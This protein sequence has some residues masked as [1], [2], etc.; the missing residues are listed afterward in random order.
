MTGSDVALMDVESGVLYDMHSPSH[1]TLRHDDSN[2]VTLLSFRKSEG[3]VRFSFKRPLLMPYKGIDNAEDVSIGNHSITVV[4]AHSRVRMDGHVPAYHDGHRGSVVVDLYRHTPMS[5]TA[6]DFLGDES[7]IVMAPNF[8]VLN[9][10]SKEYYYA[11]R[12]YHF[13]VDMHMIGYEVS[14]DHADMIHHIQ[15]YV[16]RQMSRDNLILSWN[17]G[18]KPVRFEEM[19]IF[20]PAG[21]V[22]LKF[23]FHY[24]PPSSRHIPDNSSIRLVFS[25]TLRRH[26]V[27]YFFLGAN[28]T[29]K[30][31]PVLPI[32]TDYAV[33][34][35][36]VPA[37]CL[38]R[39][40]PD[41]V[42]EMFIH[43]HLFHM[44][45]SAIA[46]A[47]SHER[48]GQELPLL[49]YNPRFDWTSYELTP[50]TSRLSI[51]RGDVVTLYCVYNPSEV[52]Q[53]YPFVSRH[54]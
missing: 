13:P 7:E 22:T 50:P 32:D 36:T 16:T 39:Q 52:T 4:Y 14:V 33:L 5:R 12:R 44:H 54:D 38:F 3:D 35:V 46:S 24:I 42:S 37:E 10:S 21:D 28:P 25:P 19:G 43:R 30:N 45:G 20:F 34:S 51:K 29:R 31:A 49:G 53:L 1:G 41:E 47:V 18:V 9:S 48:D 40:Q 23:E 27:S 2:D 6:T 17:R 26:N 15:V 11:D 8:V